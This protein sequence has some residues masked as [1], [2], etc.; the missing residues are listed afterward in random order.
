M[1]TRI[2]PMTVVSL[3]MTRAA[4]ETAGAFGGMRWAAIASGKQQ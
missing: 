3:S 4:A 2:A 1:R